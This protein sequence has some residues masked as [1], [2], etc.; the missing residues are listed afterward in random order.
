VELEG[1]AGRVVASLAR[2]AEAMG[3]LPPR[4]D[5]AAQL[6]AREIGLALPPSGP[7]PSVLVEFALR[8]FGIV[9]PPPHMVI[10]NLPRGLEREVLDQLDIRFRQI[11]KD[12]PFSRVGV[13]LVEPRDT[14]GRRRVLVALLENRVDLE[15]TPR[16]LRRGQAIQ[17]RFRT[18]PSHHSIRLVV[19]AP[20]GTIADPPLSQN[21]GRLAA[22]LECSRRGIY[23]VEVTGEG[24]HGPEVLANFPIFCDQDPP[25][26]VRYG[27]IRPLTDKVE[28]L[29]QELFEGTNRARRKRGLPA[30]KESSSL[31][32]VARRHSKDM[33]DNGFVGHVSPTTGRPIDRVRTAGIPHLVVRENVAQAYSTDEAL[34]E[35]LN[36][37]AHRQ[38]ILG[39]DVT[40][41]GVGVVVDRRA[42]TA[43]MLVTQ[44]FLKPA[45]P[46]DAATAPLE[47]LRSLRRARQKVGLPPLRSDPRLGKL[48]ADHV[49][50]LIAGERSEADRKLAAALR[51]LGGRFRRVDGLHVRLGAIEALERAEE[52]ARARYSHVGIGVGR[53]R[54]QVVIFLLLAGKK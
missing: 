39:R 2:A 54:E 23:Q 7:P 16:R 46:Y 28:L 30:L 3:H 47:V 40:E 48:A 21:G 17:L 11:L 49:R 43:V 52:I 15:P 18:A 53:D 6:A 34:R 42:S 5:R 12:K 22:R 8:S 9:D 31:A 26:E 51:R 45:K 32:E 24:Q 38:N 29:E 50:L 25:R 14:P 20:D 37:P 44:L 4:P 10:A 1:V 27:S 19:T 36:S 35:L 41:M 33:R 13:A